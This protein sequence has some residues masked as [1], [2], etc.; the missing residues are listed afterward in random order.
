M[1]APT[2]DRSDGDDT[3]DEQCN[4][5]CGHEYP[6]KPAL[7]SARLCARDELRRW[8]RGTVGVLR[9]RTA[10]SFIKSRHGSTPLSTRQ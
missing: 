1:C 8:R 2:S 7:A 9:E 5:G 10:Q 4:G 6:G 3:A